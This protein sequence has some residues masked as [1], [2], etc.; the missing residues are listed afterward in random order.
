MN[1]RLTIGK[2][3]A[4]LKMDYFKGAML[5]SRNGYYAIESANGSVT[6]FMGDLRGVY[7]Q[8]CAYSQGYYAAKQEAGE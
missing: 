6:I 4:M 7:E 8:A 5:V 3:E 1:R 2:V